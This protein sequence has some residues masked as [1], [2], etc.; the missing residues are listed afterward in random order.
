MGVN[1]FLPQVNSLIPA[2]CDLSIIGCAVYQRKK[3]LRYIYIYILRSS[4]EEKTFET[5][6]PTISLVIFG[7]TANV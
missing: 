7:A 1:V 6:I 3:L 4:F 2:V 5:H